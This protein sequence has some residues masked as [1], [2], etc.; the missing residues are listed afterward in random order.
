[1]FTNLI[2]RAT[3]GAELDFDSSNWVKRTRSFVPGVGA[4][5]ALLMAHMISGITDTEMTKLIIQWKLDNIAMK[6]RGQTE[7]PESA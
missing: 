4:R 1:M 6:K 7:N 2:K 5:L 3:K